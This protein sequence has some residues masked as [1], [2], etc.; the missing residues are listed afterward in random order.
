[1]AAIMLALSLAPAAAQIPLSNFNGDWR[2]GGRDRNAGSDPFQRTRCRTK[3][4]AD[5]RTMNTD[6]VCV[7]DAGLNKH[8][9]VTVTTE[10]DAFSGT[11]DQVA[12]RGR[13][14]QKARISG[15]RTADAA[16]MGVRL[17]FW[18]VLPEATVT[19]RLKNPDAFTMRVVDFLGNMLTDVSF[20][21]KS[22]R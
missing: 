21:R 18:S 12:T 7:G 1:M 17:K 8:I 5:A 13:N 11:L 2:G 16:V 10:G 4:E 20:Q 22:S 14:I 9:T 6:T 3:V 15:Q 19:L